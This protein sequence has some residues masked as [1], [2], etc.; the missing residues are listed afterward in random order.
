MRKQVNNEVDQVRQQLGCC[1]QHDILW[2]ELTAREHLEFF[3]RF[4]GMGG[5]V[6]GEATDSLLSDVKLLK[7]GEHQASALCSGLFW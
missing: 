5:A 3:G 4:H 2:N 6:L 1:P 7:V